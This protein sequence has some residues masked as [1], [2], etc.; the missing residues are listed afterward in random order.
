MKFKMM[1]FCGCFLNFYGFSDEEK[2][3]MEGSTE[4]QG[5]VSQ[6]LFVLIDFIWQGTYNTCSDWLLG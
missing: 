4:Q 5:G 6:F 2:K 3:Q 1:P